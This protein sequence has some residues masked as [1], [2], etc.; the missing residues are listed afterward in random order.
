MKYLKLRNSKRQVRK[1]GS[2]YTVPLY[3]YKTGGR[4]G[5]VTKEETISIKKPIIITGAHDSGKSRWLTRMYD[6]ERA[7]WGG[8]I[9]YPALWLG[10]F[11]PLAAWCENPY[12]MQWWEERRTNDK[13]EDKYRPWSNLKQ[14]ERAEVLPEYIQSTHAVIFVDD[15]H[16]LQG[17]K[18][19]IARECILAS[20]IFVLSASEEQRLAPNLR[21]VVDRRQPQTYRLG[22]EVAYD[23]T[24]PLI[25]M[26][27]IVAMGA[28]WFE[29]AMVLGGMTALSSGRRSTRQD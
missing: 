21:G 28:G 16:K 18:L 9:K 20:R 10:A 7:I 27:V 12:V 4:F 2:S 19:Q 17:R 8:K 29:L 5:K 23:M 11:R 1:D 13:D 24:K 15:A 26:I 3:V 25:W 6:Q 22:S 14:W